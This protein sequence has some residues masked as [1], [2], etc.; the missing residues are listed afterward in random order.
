MKGIRLRLTVIFVAVIICTV[1]ILEVLLIY[2]V[3]QNY[4]NSL[5]G[6]LRN[7]IKIC[8][9][10]YS[11]YYGDTSLQDNVLY[12]VD[13]FWNQSNAEVQIADQ[14]GNII[15][16]SQGILASG[17]DGSDIKA[18][19]TGETGTWIGELNGQKVMTVANP[20]KSGNEIVGALRFVASLSAVDR[21]I[22][23]TEEIFILIGLFVIL[24]VG[25]VS[26]FLANSIVVPLQ[27]ITAVAQKMAKGNYQIKS[28]KSRDDEIGELS[29]TL[30]YLADEIQKRDQ[31]KSDFISS[32]SHELR[33]PLTAIKGWAITL[34]NENF[35]QK[36][37]LNDGLN[38][39]AKESDRLTGMVE[40]LLDFSK[41]VSARIKLNPE[42]LNL[43]HL[44]EH[45]HKQLTPRAMR[46]NIEFTVDYPEDMPPIYAD[47]NRLKQ[48][49]INILD[50]A[51]NFN[52]PGGYVRF[53]A[54][55]QEQGFR[56]TIS[57]S[58]CGIG[59][60]ELPRVKEKFYKGKSSPSKN[61][62]GLSICEEIVTLMKGRL[63]IMSELNQG[64]QVV[65]FLPRGE[66][67]DD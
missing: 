32:V 23:R 64:T 2:I 54:E 66:R 51:F 12:N 9:D 44:C 56:F 29:D 19:L 42:E 46:E 6:S 30:N 7:Q 65:I 16:D 4:Y 26:V 55:V 21:D 8:T 41:F 62:I 49:F 52:H 31:L 11:K 22:L 14:N 48:L 36:E 5:E 27:E 40:D 50:N 3:K 1:A 15:M 60:D 10:M 13:T 39:I 25:S 28:R 45:L 53:Q 18:A 33:T 43:T 34:Q 61:G 67:P 58:G 35:Q 59:P 57:D 17:T 38:I 63:D 20:L 47:V 37:M 24:I